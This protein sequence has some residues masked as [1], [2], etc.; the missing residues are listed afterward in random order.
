MQPHWPS[1]LK[2]VPC[3]GL[4]ELT[5]V[6]NYWVILTVSFIMCYSN[7]YYMV[8]SRNGRRT[9]T[10]GKFLWRRWGWS[11]RFGLIL[12]WFTTDCID[13]LLVAFGGFWFMSMMYCSIFVIVCSSSRLWLMTMF[14]MG[15]HS[16]LLGWNEDVSKTM[17]SGCHWSG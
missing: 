6:Y 4:I 13:R 1:I 14:L 11:I 5:H 7:G 15:L 12:V 16:A 10:Y 9:R 8:L 3:P 17:L 2:F